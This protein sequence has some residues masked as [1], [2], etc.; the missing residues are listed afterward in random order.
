M[1]HQNVISLEGADWRV[2]YKKIYDGTASATIAEVEKMTE[3]FHATVPGNVRADLMAA[4]RLPN[5][6]VG[7]NNERANWVNECVWWYEKRFLRPRRKFKRFFLELRGIDY[8]SQ[9]YF[10]RRKLGENEG[11]FTRHL[12]D[13]S[14]LIKEENILNVRIMG[15]AFLAKPYLAPWQRIWAKMARP[16]QGNGEVFPERTATLKCQMSFGWDFAPDMRTMGIWDEVKLIGSGNVFV[17][18]VQIITSVFRELNSAKLQLKL[19]LNSTVAAALKIVIQLRPANFDGAAQTFNFNAYAKKGTEIIERNIIVEKPHLWN[20]WDRG[21]PNLYEFSLRVYCE[22]KLSD[23]MSGLIGLRDI[24]MKRNPGT[25]DG[26]TDWTFVV[27]GEPE[28]IRGANWVPADSLMG[29]VREEDYAELLGLAK[30]ASVNMLRVW[31]GGLREKRYFYEMCS[32]KGIMVWQEFPF[33]CVFLGRLPSN[34]SFFRLAEKEVISVV[35]SVANHPCVVAYCGGN[36]FS[37]TRNS[38]LLT[39]VAQA[40]RKVDTSR[41]FFPVSPA[42]GDNHNWLIWHGLENIEEYR[43]D[44]SLFV[45]EFGLQAVPC[46]ESLKRFLTPRALWPPTPEWE[47]HHADLKK[48]QRYA[49][50][51]ENYEKVEDFSLASQK[52]QALALQTAIEHYRRRK[53]ECSGAMV[54]QLNDSW[55]AISWSV[56]DYYRNPKLAY[57]KLK[58][59]YKPVLVSLVFDFKD[60]TPGEVVPLEVWIVND[61]NRTLEDCKLDVCMD[62]NGER[63]MNLSFNVETIPA[64]SSKP[65]FQFGLKLPNRE[66]W[67]LRT[68]LRYGSEIIGTN[69]YDLYFR[70]KGQATTW[71]RLYHRLGKLT[72]TY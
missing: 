51:I 25:P 43:N 5:L 6:Y 57:H 15:S 20:P 53:Y 49:G 12:Y 38:K 26:K 44:R 65:Y 48:L 67:I 69:S 22:D 35:K 1:E 31:G 72:M 11:M 71:D 7:T 70:D 21:E 39:R 32:R 19:S 59:V 52:I 66:N 60:R 37:P 68:V 50:A 14:S 4:N 46:V 56:I 28:F 18:D 58:E 16:L 36:E 42:K 10:N 54:W 8:L 63:F 24:Q 55:P 30:D 33:A 45:S 29:R 27:N 17:S 40:V 2:G 23:H 34:E 3:W 41:P 62:A 13:V 64:D 47:Y 9:V 61:L